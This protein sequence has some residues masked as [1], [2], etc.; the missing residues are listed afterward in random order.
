MPNIGRVDLSRNTSP[1]IIVSISGADQTLPDR[2]MD[3]AELR[4]DTLEDLRPRAVVEYIQRMRERLPDVPLLGT[5]RMRDQFGYWRGSEEQ[6]LELYQEITPLVDGIDMELRAKFLDDASDLA[7][8]HH[9]GMIISDHYTEEDLPAVN[10]NKKIIFE[11]PLETRRLY[12]RTDIWRKSRVC[13]TVMP[14][15]TL[16]IVAHLMRILQPRKKERTP[17]TWILMGMGR[18]GPLSRIMA[19]SLGSV[20]VYAY[21]TQIGRAH[22]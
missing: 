21:P 1:K 6:R 5:I 3:I 4:L 12:A 16:D 14:A 17:R 18:H 9:K 13:K 22:V 10:Y 11:L 19:A 2:D 20:A 15:P 8:K 7:L